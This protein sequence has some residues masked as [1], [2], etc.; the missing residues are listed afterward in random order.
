[1]YKNKNK[2]LSTGLVNKVDNLINSR[3]RKVD[4]KDCLFFISVL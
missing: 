3:S 2:K 4:K 1:M